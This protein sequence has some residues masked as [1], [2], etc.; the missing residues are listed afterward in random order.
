MSARLFSL[1][2]HCA[3]ISSCGKGG[4]DGDVCRDTPS[5]G[6][7]A[8]FDVLRCL[9]LATLSNGY[10]WCASADESEGELFIEHP[11][12]RP[13]GVTAFRDILNRAVCSD[14]D[15]SRAVHGLYRRDGV[16]HIALRLHCVSETEGVAK[17]FHD[18]SSILLARRGDSNRCQLYH[19]ACVCVLSPLVLTSYS[20]DAPTGRFHSR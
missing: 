18:A 9:R 20:G 11:C 10:G 13:A 12:L 14:G 6:A 2:V 17:V 7:V 8:A 15:E 4:C 19:C 16:C 3:Y 1:F 5:V